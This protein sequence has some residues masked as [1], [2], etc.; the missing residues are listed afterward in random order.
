MEDDKVSAVRH[1]FIGT[2]VRETEHITQHFRLFLVDHSLFG[3]LV[4]NHFDLFLCHRAF[5][6]FYADD[7][8]QQAGGDTE[9]PDER[10]GYFRQ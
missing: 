4:E 8:V 7:S 10:I 9:Q 2:F 3:A 6:V 5:F 1:Q